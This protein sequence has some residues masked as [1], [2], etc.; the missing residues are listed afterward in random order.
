MKFKILAVFAIA[1]LPLAAQAL[2]KEEKCE[3]ITNMV[4]DAAKAADAASKMHGDRKYSELS[5]DEHQEAYDSAKQSCM[6]MTDQQV[7]LSYQYKDQI[8][9]QPK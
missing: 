9:L 3:A 6:V 4:R 8:V 5:A 7:D 1:F 2:T